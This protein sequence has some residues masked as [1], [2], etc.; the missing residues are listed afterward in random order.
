MIYV[1]SR[2][3]SRA[4]HLRGTP[5]TRSRGT[6]S[7]RR[8]NFVIRVFVGRHGYAARRGGNSS[9]NSNN[10]ASC[11]DL[12]QR[13]S[14][15][16]RRRRRRR[17]CTHLMILR[18]IHTHSLRAAKRVYIYNIMYVYTFKNCTLRRHR[19]PAFTAFVD[20]RRF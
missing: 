2:V 10:I 3:E 4:A 15:C 18:Y 13:H 1:S 12:G 16:D 6:T 5:C 14:C 8:L 9:N 19:R 7:S 20:Y 17:R 11:Y